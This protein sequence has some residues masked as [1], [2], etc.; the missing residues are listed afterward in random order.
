MATRTPGGSPL[1]PNGQK[2]Q[3]FGRDWGNYTTTAG[4]PNAAGNVLT[5]QEFTLEAGDRAYVPLT[6]TTGNE[7][8]CVSA[9]TAGGGDAMWILNTGAGNL[10]P[11]SSVLYVDNVRGNDTT[12]TRGDDNLPFATIQAAINAAVTGDLIILAPQV[13]TLTATLTIPAAAVRLSITGHRESQNSSTPQF[14]V[15]LIRFL[16]GT[17]FTLGTNL[18]LSCLQLSSMSIAGATSISADGSSYAAGTFLTFGFTARDVL[19]GGALSFKYS[20]AFT[21]DVAPTLYN[22]FFASATFASC[23]SIAL[24]QCVAEGATLIVSNDPTDPLTPTSGGQLFL[25]QGCIIGT[26]TNIGGGTVQFGPGTPQLVID[27]TTAIGGIKA[28]GLTVSGASVPLLACCGF[29]GGITNSGVVDF[30][31]AGS[32][33]PDTAT[34]LTFDLRGT[35][36]YAMRQ[37]PAAGAPSGVVT[38]KFKVGGAAGNFQT[39]KLDSSTALP[40]CTFTADAKIHLTMRGADAPSAVY[41]TPGADGDILPAQFTTGPTALASI[42]QAVSFG[43]R[44]PGSTYMVAPDVDDS[45]AVYQSVSPRTTTGFTVNVAV[46]AGN[47]RGLVTYMG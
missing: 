31:S 37:L 27:E 3:Q 35:R 7:Y 5:T 45:T 23:R 39:I 42:A 17:I 30:A 22:C 12:G 40:G 6:G 20:A 14:G 13:F 24:V 11:W 32:E 44:M 16:G 25:T 29:I 43:F 19:F 21:G 28:T 46:A 41:T 26:N 8:L 9:G 34:A 18:G 38:A 2:R 36:L 1:F 15:T 10:G 4:L 33:L 47:F